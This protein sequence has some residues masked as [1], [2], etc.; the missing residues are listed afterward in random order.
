MQVSAKSDYA[1]RALVHLARHYK[2]Q[3]SEPLSI[4]VL[5]ES[6]DIPKRFLEH[7]MIELRK[8]GWVRPLPGRAGG[9]ILGKPPDE[10]TMAQIVRHFDGALA[11]IDCVSV[12]RYHCCSQEPKCSFRRIFLEIRNYAAARLE[13]ATLANIIN[14]P[15][16]TE[17]EVRGGGFRDGDGI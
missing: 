6:N 16:V 2:G 10:I 13:N 17:L 8:Q 1:L 14:G 9:F 12:Q 5:A 7:I 15:A 4:R 3:D 11:P